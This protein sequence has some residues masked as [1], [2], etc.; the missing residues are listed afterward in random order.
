LLKLKFHGTDTDT[1][2]DFLADFRTRIL[3]RKSARK[4]VSVPWNLSYTQ[5]VVEE[6][7]EWVVYVT[8]VPG[9]GTVVL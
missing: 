4:F 1:D 9:C 6:A 2:T 7:I 5:I 3:A 8:C